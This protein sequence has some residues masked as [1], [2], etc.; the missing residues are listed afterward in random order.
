MEVD[1]HM[2]PKILKYIVVDKLHRLA[3]TGFIIV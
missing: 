2:C 3:S 1:V